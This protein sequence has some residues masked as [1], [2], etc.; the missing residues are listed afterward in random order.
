MVSEETTEPEYEVIIVGG[1]P[2]GASLAARLGER[3][4]RV[5]LIERAR[6]PSLPSVPSCPL[7]YPPAM[8]LLDELGIDERLYGDETS[9]SRRFVIEF[10]DHF[11]TQIDMVRVLGRDYLYGIDRARFDQA[12][13]DNLSRYPSVTARQGF[14]FTDLLRDDAGRVIGIE[15]RADGGGAQRIR[16]R[17]VV[18]ADGRFSAVAR[19]AGARTLEDYADRTSTVHYAFWEDV[20]PYDED[21]SPKVHIHTTARG[22]DVLLFPMPEGRNVVCTHLRSD[23]VHIEGDAEG[24][25]LRKL[26]SY[27]SVQRR[28]RGARRVTDVVGMKRVANRYFQA[29][30][31]GWALTGDALQHKDPVDGQGVFD[32]LIE[33][34]LLAEALLSLRAGERTEEEALAFYERRVRE[35]TYDMFLATMDRLKRELYEEP[36]EIVL[37]TVLRW[38]LTDEVYKRRF[39]LYLSRAIPPRTW[40]TPAVMRGAIARGALGDLRRLLRP[41][42][43]AAPA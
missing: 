39:M 30:G 11:D 38:L 20:Q 23:R 42:R 27:P 43:A 40:L 18:G 12:L 19:K 31:P 37:K 15:G 14:A 7:L 5:L 32:A 24:F 28:L 1:R 35:E 33:S 22:A 21:P 8:Q 2:A 34:K 17:T 41:S 26:A 36:P 10:G 13:W 9:K 25:Y 16:A 29:G 3:G 4:V 6:L